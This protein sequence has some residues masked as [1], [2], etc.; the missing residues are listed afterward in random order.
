MYYVPTVF[1]IRQQAFFNANKDKGENIMDSD[2]YYYWRWQSNNKIRK[3]NNL[4]IITKIIAQLSF[5]IF[6]KSTEKII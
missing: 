6:K 4:V 1:K 5:A 3:S 2:Y